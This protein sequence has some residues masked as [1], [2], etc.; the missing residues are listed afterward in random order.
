MTTED[1][2]FTVTF[3]LASGGRVAT[4]MPAPDARNTFRR[5]RSLDP[6]TR[7]ELIEAI[8]VD[9]AYQIAERP[10]VWWTANDGAG[11]DWLFPTSS[12]VAIE[13]ADPS[14]EATPRPSIGFRR[15]EAGPSE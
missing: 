4:P 15:L 12:I 7:D 3:V 14:E 1:A 5:L 9:L 13:I 8:R 10:D 2:A 11:H 6:T